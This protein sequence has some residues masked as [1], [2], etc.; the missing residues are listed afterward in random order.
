[1]IFFF[2]LGFRSVIYRLPSYLYLPYSISLIHFLPLS[3]SFPQHLFFCLSS[4][5]PY[6]PFCASFLALLLP[7]FTIPPVL[8]SLPSFLYSLPLLPS[9][10]LLSLCYPPI[11]PSFLPSFLPLLPSFLPTFLVFLHFFDLLFW[12][13]S[14]L[15]SFIPSFL[16]CFCSFLF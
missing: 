14:V 11:F 16:P 9:S 2:I 12:L 4:F 13:L 8:P 7:L 5:L 6:P 1:M 3:T 15:P 10:L